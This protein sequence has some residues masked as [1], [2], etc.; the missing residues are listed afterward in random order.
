MD[1]LAEE[2]GA[3]GFQSFFLYVREAHPGE[4]LPHHTSFAQKLAHARTF[5]DEQHV[6]RPILVDGLDGPLHRLLGAMPNMTWILLR[7]GTIAYK[8]AWTATADVRRAVNEIAGIP[9]LRR[10][11]GRLAPIWT[12]RLGYRVVDQAAFMR[13][14]ERNG[15][16]AVAEFADFM[17]QTRLD[18]LDE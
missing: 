15:P 3:R 11:G 18:Q 7:G 12:E 1:E 6:R 5:R 9:E 13:G 14:L 10:Q 8:A 4:L 17:R 2:Y 16:K